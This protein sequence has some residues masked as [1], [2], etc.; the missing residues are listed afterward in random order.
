M[1]SSITNFFNWNGLEIA[2]KVENKIVKSNYAILLIHGFGAS[3]EHWRYNQKA[4]SLNAPCYSID[5]IGFGESSQPKSQIPYEVNKKDKFVYSFDNWSTQVQN[6]CKEVIKKPVF[7]VGNSIGGVIALRTAQLLEKECIGIFL[8]DCAQR[9]MD[10]KRLHE[11]ALPMRLLRPVIKTI[12][13]Q[14]V[15]S[16]NIFKFAARPKFIKKIL[17]IAYP[18]GNNINDELINI[19]ATPA[20]R[21]GAPEAFRGFINLFDDYLAPE[22]LKKN[23]KKVFL[24]WGENDPWESLAE[25]N[26]WKDTYDSIKSLDVIKKCGHCPHDEN[27]EEFNKIVLEKI[28]QAI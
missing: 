27:P 21:K 9:T 16:E 18:S 11:Q 23:N 15:F 13:R 4:L 25:A 24:I 5:L 6:F 20:K 28:Q 10:D 8:V 12:V 14:H 3:K 17:E 22:L 19:L 7:L 26:K 1:E 2:W